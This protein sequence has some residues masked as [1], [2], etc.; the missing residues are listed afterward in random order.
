MPMNKLSH[1]MN[2][3]WLSRRK[4]LSAT[5]V[6]GLGLAASGMGRMLPLRELDLF[7][8][9]LKRLSRSQLEM[10]T[11]VNVT[12]LSES[13][14]QALEATDRVFEEISRLASVMNRFQTD[15]P[16]GQ[17][18]SR[19]VLTD[20]PPELIQVLKSALYYNRVSQGYFDVTVKPVVDLYR[21][22][23]LWM[24]GSP[25][26]KDLRALRELTGSHM[27]SISGKKVS[28]DRKGMGITLDGIAK[29]YIMDRAMSSLKGSG[30]QHALIDAGGDIVALG[31][32]D[33]RHPWR[34]AIQDPRSPG[35]FLETLNL[36]DGAIATSGSYETYFD[37]EKLYHH[38][39]SPKSCIPVNDNISVTVRAGSAME[40]DAIATAAFVMG[41]RHG[42][43]WMNHIA[44]AEGLFVTGEDKRYY[45]RGWPDLA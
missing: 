30:I 17:L 15:S 41:P 40:A 2:N 12:V 23:F 10:G 24:R 35:S 33:G 16:L 1:F 45:S 32:R 9:G 27:I 34:V 4:F 26:E 3:V 8:S 22:C 6:L 21:H 31:C 11:Y 36:T 7:D 19:G 43:R 29:G 44:R 13:E 42:T 28:Y 18:N 20:V 14:V 5:G 39:V 37:R 38:L 25:S